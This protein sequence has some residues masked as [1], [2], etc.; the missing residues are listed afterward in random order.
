MI[1]LTSTN[2]SARIILYD[3]RTNVQSS[4]GRCN[5]Y[6]NVKTGRDSCDKHRRTYL[7]TF[8][9][10]TFVMEQQSAQSRVSEAFAHLHCQKQRR[11]E[12]TS[13]TR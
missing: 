8:Q 5:I 2:K 4:K 7:K 10:E 13:G 1:P 6:R 3:G 11:E 12:F 9:K